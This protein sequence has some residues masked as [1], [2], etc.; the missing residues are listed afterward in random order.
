MQCLDDWPLEGCPQTCKVLP[1]GKEHQS[2]LQ[3]IVLSEEKLIGERL[4]YQCAVLQITKINL[5]SV[6]SSFLWQCIARWPP[7][8]LAQVPK[9][10]PR[11]QFPTTQVSLRSRSSA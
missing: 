6:T 7:D 4:A 11:M 9:C 10:W 1:A 2:R 3:A 8:K 5:C